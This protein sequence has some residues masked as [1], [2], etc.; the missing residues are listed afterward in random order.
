MSPLIIDSNYV[1]HVYKHALSR[2]LEYHGNA[3]EIIFGFV[4]ETINQALLQDADNIIF[5]WDSRENLRTKIRPEY[6]A[7]RKHKELTEEEKELQ[8]SAYNQFDV[9]RKEVLPA[10]GFTNIFFQEGYESDD[11]IASIVLNI[12]DDYTVISS[13]EDLYQLLNYC[14]IYSLGKKQT[15]TCKMFDRLYEI[16]PTDWINVKAIAGCGTDNVKGAVGVGPK[17]VIEYLK[18]NLKIGKKYWQIKNFFDE[19]WYK[20]NL[21]LVKLPFEGTMIPKIQRNKCSLQKYKNVCDWY[22]FN[23]LLSDEYLRKWNKIIV[24]TR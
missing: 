24:R 4:K 12:R 5:C 23:S 22:G 8:S 13:D 3:T 1:C 2:G 18:G 9:L 16:T 14:R 10:L 7:N 6:K 11:L 19:D 17:G 15:M 20:E 21:R